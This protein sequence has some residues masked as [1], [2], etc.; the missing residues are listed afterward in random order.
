MWPFSSSETL[1]E[2]GLLKNSID[3][4]SHLLPGVDDGVQSMDETLDILENFE[5]QGI[6]QLW[7]TPHVMEDIPNTTERLKSRFAE[8]K[9]A[10]KGGIELH[11]AAEYMLDTLFDERLKEGDILPL[12]ETGNHLLVETSYFTSPMH[13]YETLS[14]IKSKGYY[15]V[16]AHP[17]RYLYMD[18]KDYK[19]L[20]AMDV[21]LQLNWA[22]LAGRY[23][24]PEQKKAE[25]LIKKDMYTVV[26]SDTH[27]LSMRHWEMKVD[28]SI[29]KKLKSA[30]VC[31]KSGEWNL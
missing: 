13:L 19:K 28:S 26:G 3:Y 20:K 16:L 8:L 15:P 4:H 2:S 10:Y 27:R 23:G 24:K 18:E 29:L 14:R 30:S 25:W 17:E 5:K 31:I 6:A 7:L 9:T 1:A 11:L 22:S 21:K 12:G